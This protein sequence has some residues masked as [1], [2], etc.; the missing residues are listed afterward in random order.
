MKNNLAM[1]IDDDETN[2][3]ISEK[4]LQLASPG[5]KT[6]VFSN[7]KEAIS[8]LSIEG[9]LLP[10]MIFLDLNMPRVSGWDFIEQ[11]E[12]LDLEN[13]FLFVLSSSDEESDQQRAMKSLKVNGYL[14]KPLMLDDVDQILNEFKFRI[15]ELAA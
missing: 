3:F 14:S 2:S 5:I 1:L 7:A 12:K 15:A 4:I 10:D 13:T 9:S 11:Y 6:I 8:Y